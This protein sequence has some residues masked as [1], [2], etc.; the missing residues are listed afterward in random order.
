MEVSAHTAVESSGQKLAV[1]ALDLKAL[2]ML[3]SDMSSYVPM[4]SYAASVVE[5]DLRHSQRNPEYCRSV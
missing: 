2:G 4:L 1:A 5:C 3:H